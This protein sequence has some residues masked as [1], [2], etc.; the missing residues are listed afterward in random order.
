ML[1]TP[2][3]TSYTNPPPPLPPFPLLL[4]RLFSPPKLSPYMTVAVMVLEGASLE[5][6]VGVAGCV[7][8][9]DG[10]GGTGGIGDGDLVFSRG[11]VLDTE[12][13]L[14]FAIVLTPKD[15]ELC[16]GE[17][18]YGDRVR[19]VE[20]EDADDS[21]MLLEMAIRG[22]PGLEWECIWEPDGEGEADEEDEE[23]PKKCREGS[24]EDGGVDEEGGRG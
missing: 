13:E 17:Y 22:G 11:D 10:S 19:A 6:A 5:E 7:E 3:P 1:H 15:E 9:D 18:V 12:Y 14:A 16:I 20:E 21:G 4:G 23:K 2:E 8:D 24:R